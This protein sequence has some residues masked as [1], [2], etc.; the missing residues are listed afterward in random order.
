M[1]E[2]TKKMEIEA[3]ASTILTLKLHEYDKKIAEAEAAVADLKKQKATFIYESN[4]QLIIGQ[5]KARQVQQAQ[6]SGT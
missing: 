4:I 2:E 3:D 5:F 6:P 1:A